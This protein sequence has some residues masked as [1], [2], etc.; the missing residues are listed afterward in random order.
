M[1][2]TAERRVD[3]GAG[4]NGEEC[5]I[6]GQQEKLLQSAKGTCDKGGGDGT[7]EAPHPQ[8]D[9]LQGEARRTCTTKHF[10]QRELRGAPLKV[11]SENHCL[12][13]FSPFL[14]H[15]SLGTG[16]APSALSPL[17]PGAELAIP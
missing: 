6:C 17:R 14:A 2:L 10:L 5:K 8:C 13:F 3:F 7:V 9:L 16:L 4:R 1:D 12:P 15:S 11:P